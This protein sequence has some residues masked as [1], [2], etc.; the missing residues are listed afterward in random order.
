MYN[1]QFEVIILLATDNRRIG[2]HHKIH[3]SLNKDLCFSTNFII[4]CIIIHHH[5]SPII[6][7]PSSIIHHP[8]SIIHHPSSI[9]IIIII[10]IIIQMEVYRYIWLRYKVIAFL[11]S[12]T[13]LPCI[14]SNSMPR[15][16]GDF[17][18]CKPQVYS[19]RRRKPWKGGAKSSIKKKH[20]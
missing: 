17:L 9:I 6:H 18:H 4:H 16:S 13:F 15:T 1:L 8:S 5:P 19:F 12:Y 20:P 10:I 7:H 2:L 3:L 14:F 11:K